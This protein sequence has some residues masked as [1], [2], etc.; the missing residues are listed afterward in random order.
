M[1]EPHWTD[2]LSDRKPFA[3]IRR[4]IMRYRNK[5]LLEERR[6]VRRALREGFSNNEILAA[7]R[8]AGET[9]LTL[10]QVMKDCLEAME[11]AR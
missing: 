7:R 3:S 9:N 2:Y 10:E 4:D 1:N 5:L 11:Q 8:Q 6:I